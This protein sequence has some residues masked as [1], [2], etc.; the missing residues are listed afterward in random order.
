MRISKIVFSLF[1][2]G[3]CQHKKTYREALEFCEEKATRNFARTQYTSTTSHTMSQMKDGTISC[4]EGGE[5][6][7]SKEVSADIEACLGTMG[8]ALED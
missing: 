5:S 8:H 2:L 4:E 7:Y 1:I 3:S 6:Q